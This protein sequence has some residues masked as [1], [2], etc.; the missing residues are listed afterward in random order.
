MKRCSSALSQGS[1]DSMPSNSSPPAIRAN[2]VAGERS[3]ERE[4]PGPLAHVLGEHQLPASEDLDLLEIGDRTLVSHVKG[5]Q[6]LDLVTKQVDPDPLVRRGPEDIDYPAPHRELSA[7]FDLVLTPVAGVHETCHEPLGVELGSLAHHDRLHVFDP[8]TEPLQQCPDRRHHDPCP[9]RGS[10]GRLVTG[11]SRRTVPQAPHRA[12]PSAHRLARRRH[13]LEG[14][15]LPCRQQLDR[16]RPEK[17]D[18]I[19]HQ[20]FGLASGRGRNEH[21]GRRS[22]I[23]EGCEHYRSGGDRHGDYR[24]LDAEE[25]GYHRLAGKQAGKL[26]KRW[27]W[28]HVDLAHARVLNRFK[29]SSGP[30]RRRH[31]TASAATSTATSSRARSAR[32]ARL[33]T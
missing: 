32:E 21:D 3:L 22:Q 19:V 7:S 4:H 15:R 14:E 10:R 25:L 23:G 11:A 26:A 17:R 16:V 28:A 8:R 29:V 1:H 20:L 18:Q 30:S 12:K 6:A 13:S 33:S 31:S 24:V 9:W 5:S 2:S 27:A